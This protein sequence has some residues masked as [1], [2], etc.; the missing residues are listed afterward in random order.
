MWRYYFEPL[1]FLPAASADSSVIPQPNAQVWVDAITSAVNALNSPITQAPGSSSPGQPRKLF[2]RLAPAPKVAIV[3]KH[4]PRDHCPPLPTPSSFL[5]D[6]E[7]LVLHGP[8]TK[9]G[10]SKFSLFKPRLL[11]LTSRRVLYF[12][13]N[14]KDK[15]GVIV[16]T[17]DAVAGVT[18]QGKRFELSAYPLGEQKTL[19]R[20]YFE[21]EPSGL[22][23]EPTAQKWVTAI[24]KSVSELWSPPPAELSDGSSAVS[25]EASLPLLGSPG[26]VTPQMAIARRGSGESLSSPNNE[27]DN[28]DEV[29]FEE[30]LQVFI[31]D[32]ERFLK[33]AK[34]AQEQLESDTLAMA[35][36]CEAVSVQFNCQD[37]ENTGDV[38]AL[39]SSTVARVSRATFA[40]K[41]QGGI[42]ATSA[43]IPISGPRVVFAGLVK[44]AN[45]LSKA[46]FKWEANH[47]IGLAEV[48]SEISGGGSDSEADDDDDED[49]LIE[50]LA[51][52]I[53]I[54]VTFEQVSF[55]CKMKI[56]TSIRPPRCPPIFFLS[57]YF[58]RTLFLFKPHMESFRYR[59]L[60]TFQLYFLL[61]IPFSSSAT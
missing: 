58:I 16:L 34:P 11:V 57:K 42:R 44:F 20:Y 38:D 59:L 37:S 14:P 46:R 17:P 25:G 18:H 26:A 2:E 51:H 31:N 49:P 21:V 33:A 10:P 61:I 32:F 6:G 30:Q 60:L 3:S 47:G 35:T 13:S 15:Q 8:V 23:D 41:A 36:V 9:Q 54:G 43:P 56:C 12:S 7:K 45:L 24:A 39:K 5:F 22:D 1:L 55:L 48:Y 40:E 27:G 19:R 4:H 29:P 50:R 53:S 28:D 52:Y